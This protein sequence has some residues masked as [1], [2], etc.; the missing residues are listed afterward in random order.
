MRIPLP[1][2]LLLLY[3][4]VQPVFVFL[5]ST[6][7]LMLL[8][9]EWLYG[10]PTMDALVGLLS[11]PGYWISMVVLTGVITFAQG[12]MLVPV[13]KPGL[14]G[15]GGRSVRLTLL[16]AGVGWALLSLSLILTLLSGVAA[17]GTWDW[18]ERQFGP[19]LP[20]EIPDGVIWAMLITTAFVCWLVPT[21]LLFIF[22]RRGERE[23][24]MTRIANY[25]LL[26]TAAEALLVIPIDAMLRRKTECY[27]AE[28]SFYGLMFL[29]AVGTLAAGPAI[30]L[31]LFARRRRGWYRTHCGS[32][33][34]DMSG[35]M[36]ASQC[37]ECGKRWRL[38]GCS[39][40]G[41]DMTGCPNAA[42]C[43][44]CGKAWVSPISGRA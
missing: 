13:R 39:R 44:E 14:T 40:C 1:I 8:P 23:D 43:P 32:C 5:G 17:L 22:T 41:Y 25:L 4:L 27:C 37:P 2:V 33:G 19:V 18:V 35:S 28:G 42:Q 6:T 7:F 10:P 36:D 3:W 38:L 16:I 30:V 29:G 34:Y 21:L 26:G 12:M 24:V 11:S 20:M 9:E 31:P 15:R